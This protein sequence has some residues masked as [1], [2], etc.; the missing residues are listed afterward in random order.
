M[1]APFERKNQAGEIYL[2]RATNVK[3]AGTKNQ[4]KSGRRFSGL[5][6]LPVPQ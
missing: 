1:G 3:T 5:P 6:E 2:R 4:K